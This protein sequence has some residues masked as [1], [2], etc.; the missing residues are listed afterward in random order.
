MRKQLKAVWFH[1]TCYNVHPKIHDAVVAFNTRTESTKKLKLER[2]MWKAGLK[3]AAWAEPVEEEEGHC[4]DRAERW[5]SLYENC[6]KKLE[7]L[8]KWKN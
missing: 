3:A 7:E 6:R 4:Y 2:L 1:G 5:L 8:K